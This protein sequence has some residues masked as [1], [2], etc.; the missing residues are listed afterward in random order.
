MY[1]RPI[2]TRLLRGMLTPEM[3]AISTLPLLVARI[4]ADHEDPAV[5]ADDLALLAH[6]FDRGSYFH[7]SFRS[8]RLFPV[9][10]TARLWRPLRS[11]LPHCRAPRA[12]RN[13][14]PRATRDVSRGRTTV[15][16]RLWVSHVRVVHL[17]DARVR[18]RGH[19]RSG[20]LVPG[21]Q[22]P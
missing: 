3:R 10:P 8:R 4:R 17:R 15:G 13:R 7:G 18:H 5:P 2:S 14:A 1:V 16:G 6:R 21:R 9:V 19:A 12:H 22:D 11:P 20:C